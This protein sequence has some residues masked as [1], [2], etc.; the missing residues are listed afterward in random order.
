MKKT[1]LI[2]DTNLWISFLISSSFIELDNLFRTGNIILLFSEESLEEFVEVVQRPR[3][4]KYFPK[5]DL[6]KLLQ[7]F[8][9][10]AELVEVKSKLTICRDPKDDFL[11]NLAIDG[12][13]DFLVTGDKDLLVIKKIKST[14]ILSFRKFLNR[15]NSE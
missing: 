8:D 10:Y 1:R 9:E 2:L 7:L 6:E 14:E 15:L 13:A 11:L 4:Q 5:K 3:L 12:K